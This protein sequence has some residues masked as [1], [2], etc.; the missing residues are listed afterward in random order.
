MGGCSFRNP[1][2][3]Y[4][5]CGCSLNSYLITNQLFH[6]LNIGRVEEMNS[7][8]RPTQGPTTQRTNSKGSQGNVS[9]IYTICIKLYF[10]HSK[11][12][13]KSN[14]KN[15]NFQ[16]HKVRSSNLTSGYIPGYLYFHVHP[17]LFAIAKA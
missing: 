10:T 5:P 1:R 15:Y 14:R 6:G 2:L 9:N 17:A 8:K 13:Y 3:N 4:V 12:T 11:I 7:H 16:D